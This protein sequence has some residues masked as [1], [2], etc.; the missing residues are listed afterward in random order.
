MNKK[1][2]LAGIITG[3]A[4][5]AAAALFSAPVSG[6]EAR[7]KVKDVQVNI[8]NNAQV[9]KM[10]LGEIKQA[11]THLKDVS[12]STIG[13]TLDGLK[14]STGIWIESAG[15][16]IEKLQHEIS[17]VQETAQELQKILPVPPLK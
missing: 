10:E 8:K 4:A 15:P 12:Q 14:T 3:I 7:E 16:H 5:G 1:S 2:L 17:E 6:R 11:V 13:E 9:M